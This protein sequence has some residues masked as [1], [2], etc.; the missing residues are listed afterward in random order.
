VGK[1]IVGYCQVSSGV[2]VPKIIEIGVFL[3]ELFQK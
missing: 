3:T 1:F 2:R